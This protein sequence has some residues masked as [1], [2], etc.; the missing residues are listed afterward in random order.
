MLTPLPAEEWGEAEYEAYGALL[1]LPGD[2]VPRAGSGHRYDP[3]HFDV[4]GV[5][6]R[7]P[8]LAR[9]FLGPEVDQVHRAFVGREDEGLVR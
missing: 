8:A 6:V 7:H 9:R 4:V 3:L 1:G 2:K 5:L